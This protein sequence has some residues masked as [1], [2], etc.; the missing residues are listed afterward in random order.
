MPSWQAQSDESTPA[1]PQTGAYASVDQ[2]LVPMVTLEERPLRHAQALEPA[3]AHALRLRRQWMIVPPSILEGEDLPGTRVNDHSTTPP[4]VWTRVTL[5]SGHTLFHHPDTR[6]SQIVD[7][8]GGIVTIGVV[9]TTRREPAL[10]E[11]LHRL[12]DADD[13]TVAGELRHFAGTYVVIRHRRDRLQLYTDPAGMMQVF[14][15]GQVVAST[16]AL[17]PPLSRDE[18]LDRAFPFGADNDWYPGTLTPFRDV[19]AVPANHVLTL[20][21]GTQERFWPTTQPDACSAV[22]GTQHLAQLLRRITRAVIET[23]PVLCSLTGGKDSRVNLAALGEHASQV[24]FFTVTGPGVRACDVRI[25]Q[26]LAEQRDLDHRFVDNVTAE[27]WVVALYDEMTSEMVVG[28]RRDVVGAATA[29]AGPDYIHLNGNLGALAKSFFWH[30]RN[31]SS[32]RTRTLAK[33]FT[34]RP[35]PIRDAIATWLRSTPPLDPTTIY[36]LMYLEQRGGRWMGIGEAA[37]NLFYDSF[38]PFCSR[39][40][41]ETI[42]GLPTATQYG[43]RLL[44]DL[45]AV[46]APDLSAVEYCPSPRNWSTHLPRRLKNQL[47]R[48][49]S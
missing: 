3:T 47:K 44:V 29:L 11:Q 23:G 28:G 10:A 9:V 45:V 38:T 15:K 48:L 35:E 22:D 14:R 30:S 8:D 46:L 25:A 49:R 27:P 17:L 36:N 7:G 41:F 39:E 33:E 4:A 2:A 12:V 43:G 32:V 19:R 13:A 6:V 42:C 40:V 1:N 31:P 37:S 5:L 18:E 20:P 34:H 24:E 26:T 16:P 21:D